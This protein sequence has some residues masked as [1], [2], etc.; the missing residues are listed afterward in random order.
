MKVLITGGAG[1][2]GTELT[3]Q[4]EKDPNINEIILYDN[5]S[6][7]NYNIFLHSRIK[8]GKVKFIKGDI[9]D[10]RKLKEILKGIDIVY[11][12]AAR[13][14]TPFSN[15][16]PHLFEQVNNWGTAELVYA[17]EESKVKKFIYLS[18]SSVYG[19]SDNK[20]DINTLPNPE[21]FYGITKLQGEKHVERL[22]NK[23]ETYIIRSGNV[24]GFGVSMRFDAVINKFMFD[25]SFS[26]RISVNGN[27][28]Q[29]RA[30]V[31]IDK[32]VSVL[33]NINSSGLNSGTYNLVDK[34]L[35]VIEL[36][37]L[38]KEIYPN[39]EMLFINQHLKLRELIVIPDERI[40]KLI[41]IPEKTLKEE[42]E[43]FS[44]KFHNSSIE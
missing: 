20:V 38:I 32:L 5:L 40:Q 13:V 35:S 24:Y 1:Y 15:E 9:L 16:S 21:T 18:S 8:R 29:H 7:N 31:H 6:R 30:F 12:L 36:S 11:H 34:N 44:V 37:E 3:I 25:A 10:S 33:K 23:I 41:T 26:G 39:I 17:V 14:T 2:I 22:F 19:S 4:L 42:F 43:E 27:G 28:K